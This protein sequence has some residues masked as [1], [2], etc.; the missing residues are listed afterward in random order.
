MKKTERF[1]EEQAGELRKAA[2]ASVE[3]QKD[4]EIKD[5]DAQ[6]VAGGAPFS[7]RDPDSKE[8]VLPVV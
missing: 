3:A 7:G 1:H 2:D 4:G 6:N 8:R 5:E